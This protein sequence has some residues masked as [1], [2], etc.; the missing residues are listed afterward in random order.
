MCHTKFEDIN[1]ERVVKKKTNLP[2]VV[3]HT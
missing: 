1:E 3:V 2:G